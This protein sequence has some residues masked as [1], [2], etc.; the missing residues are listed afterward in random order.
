MGDFECDVWFSP[1]V[2]WEIKGADIQISPV[3]QCASDILD[4]RGLGIRFPRL[5]QVREDKTCEEATTDEFIYD[6]Y[7]QQ[8]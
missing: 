6:I 3:Y 1:E 8:A 7:R 2:V 5:I 4:G